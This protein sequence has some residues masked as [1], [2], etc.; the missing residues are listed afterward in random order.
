MQILYFNSFLRNL[1]KLPSERRIQIETTI[2]RL[3]S[4]LEDKTQMPVGMGLKKLAR[5]NFW[6]IRVGLA[7]R[8][9]FTIESGAL[10]FVF[11]GSHDEIKRYLTH[12]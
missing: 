2:T 5:G 1:K 4:Y 8:I 3:I 11:V 9:I 6:E 12:T 7:I 10:S